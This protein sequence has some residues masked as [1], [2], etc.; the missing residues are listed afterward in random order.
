MEIKVIF[1]KDKETK[2][3]IGFLPQLDARWGKILSYVRMGQHFEADTEYYQTQTIRAEEKEYKSLFN[4]MQAIYDGELVLRKR[5]N[6]KD[7]FWV[8]KLKDV[9]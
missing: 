8:N 4:E 6:H 3:I 9:D 2:E 5:L 1:R 7:L